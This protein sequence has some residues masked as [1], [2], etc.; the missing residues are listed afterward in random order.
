MAHQLVIVAAERVARHIGDGLVAERPLRV[1][2]SIRPVI[3]ACADAAHRARDKL[4][5][6][7]SLAAVPA[8]VPHLARETRSQP[9]EEAGFV[10]GE[11]DVRNADA[12]KT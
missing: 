1:L 12:G 6:S 10:L 11:I 2:G 5:G 8:H 3:H 7:R 4:R 9:I